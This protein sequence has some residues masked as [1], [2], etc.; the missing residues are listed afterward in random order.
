MTEKVGA[1]AL[2]LYVMFVAPPEKEVE[3]NDKG[4]EGS[5]RWLHARVA[6]RA[7]VASGAGGCDS[8]LRS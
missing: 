2:R 3:W 8:T 6:R 7:A 5:A 4:L 1:D